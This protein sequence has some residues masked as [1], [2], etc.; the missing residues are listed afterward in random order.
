VKGDDGYPRL[1]SGLSRDS[2]EM[3]SVR[4]TEKFAEDSHGSTL[5]SRRVWRRACPLTVLNFRFSACDTFAADVLLG[6]GRIGVY[7]S[8]A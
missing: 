1:G 3:R 5:A 7:L 8:L 2:A 6:C 4:F